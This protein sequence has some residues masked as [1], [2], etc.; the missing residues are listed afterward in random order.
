MLTDIAWKWC[1]LTMYMYNVIHVGVS[2][3]QNVH[4]RNLIAVY[5]GLLVIN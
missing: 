3:D 4:Q 5:S 1:H 2:P